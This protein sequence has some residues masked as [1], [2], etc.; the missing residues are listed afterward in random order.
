MFLCVWWC[1]CACTVVRGS[2]YGDMMRWM[3]SVMCL[4]CPLTINGVI[5]QSPVC[6]HVSL[7]ACCETDP[8]FSTLAISVGQLSTCKYIAMELVP[9]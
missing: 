4:H 6:P 2:V 5:P 1:I 8:F 9:C 3:L 7:S